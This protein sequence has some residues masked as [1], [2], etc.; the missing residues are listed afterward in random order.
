MGRAHSTAKIAIYQLMMTVTDGGVETHCWE[1]AKRLAE[2]GHQVHVFGGWG[3]RR[4]NLPASS[5]VIT[6]PYLPRRFVPHPRKSIRKFVERLSFGA[7]ALWPLVI[8]RY[9]L[10]YLRKPYDLP[11]AL[12]VKALTG[13]RVIYASGGT[14]FF[15]GCRGLMSKVDGF[16]AC[17]RFNAEQIYDHCGL[18]PK[19]L[20]NGVDVKTFVP[21]KPASELKKA[22]GIG[23]TDHVLV[24]VCRLVEVKGLNWAIRA[25]AALKEKQ[26]SVRYLI[27]GEGPAKRD[28]E[29]LAADLN[30]AKEVCFLGRKNHKEIPAF[31]GI[32]EA[33]V[34]P[35]IAHETFGI[36]I[37]EAMA[38]GVPVVA[39]RLGG[40]PE[41]VGDAGVLVPVRDAGALAA[42][43]GAIMT[44]PDLRLR[45]REQ[46]RRRIV[47][48]FNWDLVVDRLEEHLKSILPS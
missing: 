39:T 40:I 31:Y 16:Y 10:I 29:Q 1:V 13:A 9:D 46:G 33:A 8:N 43:L 3:P 35:S 20:H 15:A 30:V 34:F 24:S 44:D 42:A 36:A 38:C 11:I 32:A 6:L 22:L 23:E 12:L 37:A 21:Q 17:S 48:H 47:A 41:V 2:R 4:R 7:L 19:V 5:R 26:L 14:E 28:L 45:L 25:V 18:L 27:I